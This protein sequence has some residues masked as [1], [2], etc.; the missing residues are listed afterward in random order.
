MG[1]CVSFE[2]TCPTYNYQLNKRTGYRKIVGKSEQNKKL[3]TRWKL[4]QESN[5]KY[6]RGAPDEVDTL[7]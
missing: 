1:S 6:S 7:R 2:M 3:N 5:A 4:K